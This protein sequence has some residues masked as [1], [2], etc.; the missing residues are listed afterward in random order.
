MLEGD[1]K[2]RPLALLILGVILLL[3]PVVGFLISPVYGCS[4]GSG[5]CGLIWGPLSLVLM[6][7]PGSVFIFA[8]IYDFRSRWH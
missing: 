4:A 6:F 7:V 2:R 8:S 5:G 1:F 3:I